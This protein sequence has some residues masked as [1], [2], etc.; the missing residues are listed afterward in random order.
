MTSIDE[1]IKNRQYKA[2]KGLKI[3]IVLSEYNSKIGEAMHE[4][5]IKT[6][7]DS[8]VE[9]GNIQTFRVPGAFEIPFVSQ[10][11]SKKKQYHAIITL[12]T[13]IRGETPHF[14]YIASSCAQSIM[15]VSLKEDIPII[16]GVL[17]T[18]TLSQAE[19]RINKGV[20]VALA[21]LQITNLTF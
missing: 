18:N 2:K 20:E 19:G 4:K 8:G 15:N 12:G 13:L 21:T 10:K 16:F 5:C 7:I 17:T 6:L 14:E 9:E 11:I 1:Q 3:A